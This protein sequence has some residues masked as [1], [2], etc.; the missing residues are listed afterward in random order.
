MSHANLYVQLCIC[1]LSCK[2]FSDK[3]EVKQQ[4]TDPGTTDEVLL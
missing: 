3:E 4:V 1:I 2:S